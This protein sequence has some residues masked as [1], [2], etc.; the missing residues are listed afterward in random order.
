MNK[1][2]NISLL[3]LSFALGCLF[4]YL[5]LPFLPLKYEPRKN[6]FYKNDTF[7]KP[8]I[9]FHAS[10]DKNIKL[11]EPRE[12]K[13]RSK[14]EGAVIFSTPHIGFASIFMS[15]HDD[16]WTKSGSF[17]SGS[18]YLICKDKDR[19][20]K[21][22][23]GGAIYCLPSDCFYADCCKG[24]G[25]SEWVSKEAV[26]PLHKLEFDSTLDAMMS[27][28]VQVYFV[29]EKIFDQIKRDKDHGRKIIM[30]LKSENEKRDI[31]PMPLFDYSKYK[32]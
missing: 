26:K 4:F 10:K 9:L 6:I 29:D 23:D 11:L 13:R 1:I 30:N 8:R 15:R 22:D 19:F 25:I 7:I 14:D 2:K 16:R 27:F 32:K 28:G 20:I 18:F 17:D 3:V 12:I 5:L 21:E 24:M 31:N